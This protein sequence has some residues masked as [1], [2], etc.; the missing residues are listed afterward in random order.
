MSYE[1]TPNLFTASD[2]FPALQPFTGNA[3]ILPSAWECVALLHP[4]SPIQSNSTPND[5]SNPFFELCTAYINYQQGEF[6]SAQLTG[7]SGR[8]WWYIIYQSET[9]LSTDQGNSFNSV[10]IG[11]TLP[12]VN[13]LGDNPTCAGTGFLNWMEAQT[14]NWWKIPVG[15]AN[16]PPAT[17]MWFDSNSELPVRQMFGQ[18][19]PSPSMGDPNQL[20]LFQ[21]FSFNYFPVFNPL[22]STSVPNEWKVFGLEGFS[23]G[24]PNNYNL[25]TW[26][27]NFGMTVFMT[28]VNEKFNPL[29]TQVLYTWK[30]D[31]QYEVTSDRSQNTSMFFNY[32]PTNPYQM[33]SALL[34]GPAPQTVAPP[35]NSD[36]GFL[37]NYTNGEV[38]ACV[39]GSNFPFPQEPPNWVQIQGEDGT[40]QATVSNN[41][42]LCPEN[43]VNIL[44]VLFPPSGNNYPDSTY[45]WTWYSPLNEDG[46]SS[47]PVTFMQSQSGVGLGTSLALADYFYYEEFEEWLSPFYFEIPS[48]CLIP[49]KSS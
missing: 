17:W 29:T 26:N 33:Q 19:P 11:W 7:S 35:P 16:P 45:L 39:G 4:F 23:F 36:S 48:M 37:I 31:G 32:N 13:W 40:I 1:N 25:F 10:D 6:M 20:A 43:T 41:P 14:V 12:D 28:P 3:P 30:P 15:T 24:N 38:S 9:L 47:R 21:M 18:G 22:Q 42:V 27:P 46:S 5:Q 8:T 34:T 49:T 2:V 44:S